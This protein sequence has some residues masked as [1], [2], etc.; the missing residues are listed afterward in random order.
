[1]SSV[2]PMVVAGGLTLALFGLVVWTLV[3]SVVGIVVLLAGVV[4]W[5]RDL[6]ADA[7]PPDHDPQDHPRDREEHAHERR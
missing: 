1:M 4:G 7:E 6:L 2:W 3:Y 5:V